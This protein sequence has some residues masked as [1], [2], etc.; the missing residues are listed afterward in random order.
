MTIEATIEDW[1]SWT[2]L[3]FPQSG[4]YVIPGGASP[5]QIKRE[6]NSGTYYDPNIWVAYRFTQTRKDTANPERLVLR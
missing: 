2:G 1:E 6:T 3:S 5:L 4:R